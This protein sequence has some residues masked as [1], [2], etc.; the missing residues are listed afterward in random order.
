MKPHVADWQTLIH[1]LRIVPTIGATIYLTDYVTDLTIGGQL[2]RSDSGY[3]FSG[4][5][6]EAGM[7]PGTID[8]AGIMNLAGVDR[9]AVASGYFDN[10]K[11]YL[12]ATS[13]TAP[14][15]DEEPIGKLTCGKTI[16]NGDRYSIQLMMLIDALNQ[17]IGKTYIAT[18]PKQFGGQEYAGCKVDL[19]PITVTG[20]VTSVTS[21]YVF[22]D[23]ARTEAADYFGAGTIRW[24]TGENVGQRLQEVKSYAADGTITI[25]ET[26]H[27]PV[28]VGDT[29]ELAPGCRKRADEDCRDKWGNTPNF[30]GFTRIPSGTTYAARGTK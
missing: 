1:C 30:G 20:T 7:T 29:Y 15:V 27:Y 28:E 18:C 12:F 14:T 22:R 21:R 17:P 3:E 16:I 8:L 25:H 6:T 11:V 10:A 26:F 23:S 19:G 4:V 13:W 24:T 2:Y 9:D 5:A